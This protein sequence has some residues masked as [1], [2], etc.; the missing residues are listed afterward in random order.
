MEIYIFKIQN[1]L[2]HQIGGLMLKDNDQK[3]TFTQNYF[4]DLNMNNQFQRRQKI[5]LDLN[6][7]ILKEMQIKEEIIQ[8]ISHFEATQFF[9][10]LDLESVLTKDKSKN[11]AYTSDRE[12]NKVNFII[13]DD[14]N[15]NEKIKSVDNDD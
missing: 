2:Y 15:N 11:R 1:E 4:Y 7:E 9:K 5:F 12:D 14:D 6:A 13:L 8:N 10:K 3:L